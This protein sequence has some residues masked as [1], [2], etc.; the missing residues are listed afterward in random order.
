MPK[1]AATPPPADD[2]PRYLTVVH[3]FVPSGHCNM[4]LPKDRQDFARWIACCIDKD[5][6]YTFFHKPSARD[7]V[8]IEVK[9][10]Y[11][12][13]DRLLGEHRW[14]EFLRNPSDELK[15]QATR[16][17]YCTYSTG[18]IVQK[19]GECPVRVLVLGLG[20]GAER[21]VV[22]VVSWK[23]EIGLRHC[24]STPSPVCTFC[25]AYAYD[26]ITGWKRVEI[27]DEWFKSWSPN[28][29]LGFWATSWFDCRIQSHS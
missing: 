1:R 3:P 23:N 27:K 26:S 12:H 20:C 11:P 7:M 5:A 21:W 16:V 2:E 14:S 19:N 18:R 15:N 4:E 6:I 10:D 22:V 29:R 9:R 28:N 8:I 17:Y 25:L 24:H 13:F